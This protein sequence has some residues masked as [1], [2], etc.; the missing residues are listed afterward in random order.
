[1]LWKY[2]SV[3]ELIIFMWTAEVQIYWQSPLLFCGLFDFFALWLARDVSPAAGEL[4]FDDLRWHVAWRVSGNICLWLFMLNISVSLLLVMFKHKG[5]YFKTNTSVTSSMLSRKH[6]YQLTS[7]T[8]V[9]FDDLW[10]HVAW[11]VSGNIC[12]WLFMLNISVSLLLV[13]FKHKGQYFKTNTS[14]TS[15]MLSRKHTY[16]L[17]STT[18][19]TFALACR[20]I[21]GFS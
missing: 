4:R 13:M 17:T 1:M 7:T 6:T 10:W 21:P 20:F 9:R 8:S 5:Q 15:S 2:A 12:L 3:V 14:V 16:Q 11:R 18:F 19:V